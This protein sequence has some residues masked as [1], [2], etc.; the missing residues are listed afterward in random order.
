MPIAPDYFEI[1]PGEQGLSGT[2]VQFGWQIHPFGIPAFLTPSARYCANRAFNGSDAGVSLEF[3]LS[4]EWR[5][6]SSVEPV[7]TC[8]NNS[9][10][11]GAGLRQF[12][13]DVFWEKN[14]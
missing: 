12:G 5:V 7:R 11:P 2:Q 9:T 1:S 8:T 13:V 14:Y 4:K 3:R 10:I 6:A